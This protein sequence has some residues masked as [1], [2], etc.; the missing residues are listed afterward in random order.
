MKLL[1]TGARGQLGTE[2]QALLQEGGCSLGTLPESIRKAN[3]IPISSDSLNYD[4]IDSVRGCFSALSPDVIINCVAYTNVNACEAERDDAFR[5]NALVPR[6][7]AIAAEESGSVLIHV[8][9][10]YVFDGRTDEPYHEWDLCNPQN[11][12]GKSKLMGEQYVR[13][14]CRRYMVVRTSWLYGRHG[15]NFVKAI[16][17]AAEEKGI[18]KIVNDQFGNPTNAEDLAY[19]LLRLANTCDYGLYH[20]T[21]NGVCTWYDFAYEFIKLSGNTCSITPCSTKEYPSPARRPAYSAL[22]NCM[23]RCTIG[24]NMRD[25]QEAIKDYM[26]KL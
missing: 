23:L 5:L 17:K 11:V 26:S 15:G 18:V 6:N 7:F 2:L 8:S 21:G 24:D 9:T 1:I 20:C 10:D 25:W 14:F 3:V 4:D 12:Y 13:E 22:D 19:H 16:L